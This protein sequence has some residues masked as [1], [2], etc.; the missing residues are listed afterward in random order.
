[1]KIAILGAGAYGQALA[2]ILT[3]NQHQISYYD[4]ALY[5]EITLE[6]ATFE[7]DAVV[8][9]IPSM[10]LD[11]FV[12]E[13]PDSL[14]KLPTILASKGMMD[15]DR[16]AEFTQFSVISGPGFAEEIMEVLAELGGFKVSKVYDT[17]GYFFLGYTMELKE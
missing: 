11:S 5:P 3:D 17:T 10:Y 4:P 6:V 7:A 13:Y 16:F 15:V 1:M 8:I 14:K 9:T 2:K 12:D